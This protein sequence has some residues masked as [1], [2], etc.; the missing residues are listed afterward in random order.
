[1]EKT[2]KEYK[3]MSVKEF[4][5][6][7]KIYDSGH[8]GIYEICKYDYPKVHAELENIEFKDVLDCG[9]GTGPMV[10]ILTEKYPDK[11]YT[12]LDLTPEM[13]KKAKKKN[14]K[15][16]EFVVGDCENLPF[17]DESF[18]VI[19]CTNSFHHYPNPQ[20]F[21][22]NVYRVLRKNGRLILRDYTSNGVV[23]W[24]M[25][26]IELPLARLVGHGDV[27]VYK[28]EEFKEMLEKAGFTKMKIK[29]EEK[30][31]CHVVAVKTK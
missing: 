13:I 18:D 22:D 23:L 19:I 2:S 25:N 27:K 3:N 4:T 5:K 9:C 14:L 10:E 11:Q 31:R 1:M 17:A 29:E 21:F 8:S 30:F 28:R 12:G 15:N 20:A 24:F 16:T 7:A 26:H 6:A